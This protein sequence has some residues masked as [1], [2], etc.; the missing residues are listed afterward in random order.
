MSKHSVDLLADAVADRVTDRIID[1]VVD[2]LLKWWI[3]GE[4]VWLDTVA[5]RLAVQLVEHGVAVRWVERA[6][7]VVTTNGAHPT[8][9]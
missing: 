7:P 2:R 6:E 1:G 3:A 5:E 9:P 4:D 8:E